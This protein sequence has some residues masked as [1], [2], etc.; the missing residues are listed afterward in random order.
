MN[1]AGTKLMTISDMSEVQ[2]DMEV[3]ETDV[4]A[5]SVGDSASLRIDAFPGRT[6]TGKVTR[7]G[8][9]ALAG[10]GTAAAAAGGEQQSVDY[11]VVITL[12]NP[13]AELRPDLST[14]AEIITDTRRQ[15]LAVPIIALTVRDSAGK[16]FKSGVDAKPG[17]EYRFLVRNGDK[18]LSRIDPR[19]RRLTNSV[20][21]AIVYDP[22]QRQYVMYCRA[23]AIYRAGGTDL[24]DTGE[25]RRVA[26][27]T[28]KELW[29]EWPREAKHILLPDELDT[30]QRY[31][32]FY[33]M[34]TTVYAGVFFS[35]LWP[36]R[37]ND[38]IH[39]ELAWWGHDPEQFIIELKGTD[40]KATMRVPTGE[41]STEHLRPT[42]VRDGRTF[43]LDAPGPWLLSATQLRESAAR[44]GEWESD[45]TTASRWNALPY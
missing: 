15:A 38:R 45:F 12:D 27:V 7:I 32:A 41:A 1:N 31:H 13:P 19:A 36:F 17:D 22:H 24:I 26:R 4:P 11:E 6:F 43:V 2:A 40:G 16:K 30:K 28:S 20:G 39:T 8:N 33:G 25:S 42:I 10:A 9:S 34:P 23:K 5:I 29:A 35:F 37:W 44:P 14:T 3:D 18:V 21:N